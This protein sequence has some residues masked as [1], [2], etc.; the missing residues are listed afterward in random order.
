[1][2]GWHNALGEDGQCL[3]ILSVLPRSTPDARVPDL[4]RE[5]SLREAINE[6]FRIAGEDGHARVLLDVTTLGRDEPDFTTEQNVPLRELAERL[7]GTFGSDGKSASKLRI[8]KPDDDPLSFVASGSTDTQEA[9]SGP[10]AALRRL[11]DAVHRLFGSLAGEGPRP[12]IL[13]LLVAPSPADEK[14]T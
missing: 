3:T 6:I 12:T 14:L 7:Y 4:D 1:M 9:E 2:A 8:L 13:R 11:R 5:L 10:I